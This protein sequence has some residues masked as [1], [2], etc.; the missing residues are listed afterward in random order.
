MANEVG[1]DDGDSEKRGETNLVCIVSSDALKRME[2]VPDMSDEKIDRMTIWNQ[3]EDHVD[4]ESDGETRQ[5][6]V[7][8]EARGLPRSA[9][10]AVLDEAFGGI[11]V[12]VVVTHERQPL[13]EDV[14][15]GMLD[16]LKEEERIRG[17]TLVELCDVFVQVRGVA[18]GDVVDG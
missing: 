11:A 10:L 15:V 16:E 12:R 2:Y 14:V 7:A 18:H 4:G 5:V 9:G 8:A 6:I 3:V 13:G 17:K 1:V